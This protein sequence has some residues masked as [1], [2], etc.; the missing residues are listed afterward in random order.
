[1]SQQY[2]PTE[3]EGTEH[4]MK[5]QFGHL[6]PLTKTEIETLWE[7]ATLTVD[8]NVLLDLYRYHPEI[9]DALIGALHAFEGRLWLSHQAAS[10]FIRNRAGAA[11]VVSKELTDADG[12]LTSLQAATKK[13]TDDLRG[14]RPLSRH[15]GKRLR[16]DVE[17]AIR[18]A[19][20][21]V[22][23]QRARAAD[24]E[25][26]DA[27]LNEVLSLFDGCVGPVP[28]EVELAELHKEAERR[29]K[30][31]VPPGFEDVKKGAGAHGDYLMWQQV[32]QQVKISAKP[33]I[34]VT[35]ERKEDWWE[36]AHGKTVGPRYELLEEAH[37]VAGQRV[38]LYRT[39]SFIEQTIGPLDGWLAALLLGDIRSHDRD[40]AV[41]FAHDELN[42]V[43]DD[44]VEGLGI[45]LVATDASVQQLLAETKG[46]TWR[47]RIVDVPTVEP[48]DGAAQLRFTAIVQYTSTMPAGGT[49]AGPQIQARIQG[50]I[51]FKDG[52]WLI[53][54]HAVESAEIERTHDRT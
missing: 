47:A 16:E 32:L 8:A 49:R 6:L 54:E 52:V 3:G 4:P 2:C 28:T 48:M 46:V 39:D 1:M 33:M 18:V 10:E 37:R 51:I 25:S 34:L 31:K 41:E 43:M 14:R 40:D 22:E 5:K 30:E 9:R 13:A 11:A 12:D 19:K 20:A 24:G 21:A 53:S 44:L 23:E 17:A 35:S 36:R 38:L 26:S 50:T 15:V 42:E 7:E 27:V 29:I 45:Q